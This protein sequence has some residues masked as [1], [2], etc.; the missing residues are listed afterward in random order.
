MAEGLVV[1]SLA[2]SAGGNASAPRS[3]SLIP[4]S[5]S[6]ASGMSSRLDRKEGVPEIT[7]T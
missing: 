4:E 7:S 3:Y 2:Y 6:A 1:R 5:A